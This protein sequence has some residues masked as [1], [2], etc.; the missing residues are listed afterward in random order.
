MDHGEVERTEI[1]IE[2]EVGQVVV[3]VKEESIL[4]VLR[5][6]CIRNPV[7]LVYK[8]VKDIGQLPVER[9]RANYDSLTLNNFD[10]FTEDLVP[11]WRL[12]GLV[13]I[14][15]ARLLQRA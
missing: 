14:A 4:E 5:R 13:V 3:N 10:W 6:L 2:R 12:V 11:V 15:G 7:Q 9:P 8:I 1:F